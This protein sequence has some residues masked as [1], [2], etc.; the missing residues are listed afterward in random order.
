MWKKCRK[1]AEQARGHLASQD[2]AQATVFIELGGCISLKP[3]EV[4][5]TLKITLLNS[6][7]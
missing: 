2:A 6:H 7:G 1:N 3:G 4:C 5:D